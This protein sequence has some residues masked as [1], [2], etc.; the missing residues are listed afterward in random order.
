MPQPPPLLWQEDTRQFLMRLAI[1]SR[2]LQGSQRAAA[3]EMVN[4]MGTGYLEHAR[5]AGALARQQEAACIAC[6][7]IYMGPASA[8]LAGLPAG[9]M[10]MDDDMFVGVV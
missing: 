9:S 2:A 7:S 5:G 3:D 8:F 1:E 10:T 4:R 6:M